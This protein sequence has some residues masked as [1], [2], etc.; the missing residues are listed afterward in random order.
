MYHFDEALQAFLKKIRSILKDKI[1]EIIVLRDV[2]GRISCHVSTN[3]NAEILSRFEE[4][5]EADKNLKLYYA[6]SPVIAHES[7]DPIWKRMQKLGQPLDDTS[8]IRVIERILEGRSWFQATS[9]P[10]ISPPPYI[11]TFYSFKGGVG[12]TTA[13]ALVARQ[14]ALQGNGERICLID[15]DF[16]APG[17]SNLA[18]DKSL[19]Q[20]PSVGVIDYLLERRLVPEKS[21]PMED[22]LVRIT[23]P[24]IEKS[25]GDL[26][27]M[28]AGIIEEHYLNKLGRLDLQAMLMPDTAA[29]G[30]NEFPQFT[31]A[32]NH[33]FQ[34]LQS[35]FAF[36]YYIVDSRTGITDIGGLALNGLSHLNVMLFGLGEQNTRG[37][38]F[39][40][41]HLRP[42]FEAQALTPEQIAG[43]L[44]IAFSPIPW[45]R[46]RLKDE[47][48][49]NELRE[50]TYGVVME[51]IYKP[52][53]PT[54]LSFPDVGDDEIPNEP[55]PHHPV[56]IPYLEDL[57]L[58]ETLEDM[59]YVQSQHFS[60]PYNQLTRRIYEVKL[61][62][63]GKP[64]SSEKIIISDDVLNSTRQ[65]LSS[66]QITGAAEDDLN[67]EAALREQ[68]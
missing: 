52:L 51:Q 9:P 50:V 61:P 63:L 64:T 53:W 4:S 45:G 60:A 35:H 6:S 47:E 27:L 5:L 10:F 55:V 67:S 33:L 8:N 36:D 11:I 29:L 48:L 12:R 19:I 18:L 43:R 28:P 46:G 25:G 56:I 66:L 34:D 65:E 15:F 42:H 44:L 40:L 32:L 39:V 22:Y 16:E 31:S 41:E 26:W 30:K 14:L 57:P 7:D 59:D 21:L 24:E 2:Y 49:E 38:E 1:Q 3:N 20:S 17:L 37:M 58:Q 62:L 54:S 68:F 13:A 23:D